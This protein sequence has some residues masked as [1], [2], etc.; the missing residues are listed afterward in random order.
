MKILLQDKA[1]YPAI[2][3][4]S[5]CLNIEAVICTDENPNTRGY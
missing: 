5:P 3:V 4:T 1:F 2:Q